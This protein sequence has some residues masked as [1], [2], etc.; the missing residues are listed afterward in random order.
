MTSNSIFSFLKFAGVPKMMSRCITPNGYVGFPGTI[1][2]EG[3]LCWQE[4]IHWD[5]DLPQC[6]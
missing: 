2:V 1:S 5:L 3:S 4:I 6:I